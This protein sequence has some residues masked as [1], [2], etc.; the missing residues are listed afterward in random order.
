MGGLED[1]VTTHIVDVPARGDTD[2]TDLGGQG[3]GEVVAVEVGRGNDIEIS[4]TGEHLLQ[5]DVSDGVLHQQLVARLP[6][7]IVP[8]H[9]DVG[10]LLPDHV[11]SP[12][13]EG[14]F[15]ELLDVPLVHNGHAGTAVFEGVLDGRPDQ[16]LGA[17]LGDRLDADSRAFPNFPSHL[18]PEECRQFGRLRSERLDLETRVDVLGV[19]AKDHHVDQFGAEHRRRDSGEPTHRPEADVEVEDPAQS[20]VQRSDAATDRRGQRALDADQMGAKCL[21]RLVGQPTPRLVERL[22]PGQDFL[23]RHLVAALGRGG[24]EHRFGRRPDVHADA[25]AF[26]E[27]NDGLFGYM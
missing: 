24:V 17:E 10:E 6:A 19:L 21:D 9:G 7:A 27:R 18:V 11:I 20:H 15:G 26:D 8:T 16:A 23:P 14:A 13:P 5:G 1:A 4:R 22:L 3:I 12:V 2:P 25:V